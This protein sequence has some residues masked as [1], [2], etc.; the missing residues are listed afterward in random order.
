VG[1]TE[2]A[3]FT[4]LDRIQAAQQAID[5]EHAQLHGL[6]GRL[7]KAKDLEELRVL[8]QELGQWLGGHFAREESPEGLHGLVARRAPQFAPA[9][10]SLMSEHQ[11]FLDQVARL[12]DAAIAKLRQVLGAD[13]QALGYRSP[14]WDLSAESVALLNDRGFLYDSSM[15]AD[16]FTPYR[17]RC[18]DRVDEE[19]F[20][21][22]TVTSLVEMPVAWELDDFPY[23]S[24]TNRPL[25]GGMHSPDHVYDCL[26]GEFDYCHARVPDGVF[27]LTMHPQVIGR[28][29]RMMMLSRLIDHMQA[30]GGVVFRTLA[31]EARRQH[32]RLAPPA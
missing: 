17:A 20:V 3:Q 12:L 22:G 19:R 27:T 6:A 10:D 7:A 31:G 16:D 15:M 8:L 11:G 29:P 5:E 18:G 26:R 30:Q 9:F 13:F 14:A 2:E 24:F 32:E 21:P 25:F 23:F 28:G 1:S 4:D